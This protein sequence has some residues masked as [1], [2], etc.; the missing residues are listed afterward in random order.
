MALTRGRRCRTDDNL[1]STVVL[2]GQQWKLEDVMNVLIT[3]LVQMGIRTDKAL[4]G[5][6]DILQ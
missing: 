6:G 4:G 1:P 3:V 2:I 5:N